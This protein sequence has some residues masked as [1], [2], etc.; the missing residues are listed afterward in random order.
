MTTSHKIAMLSTIWHLLRRFPKPRYGPYG[1]KGGIQVEILT[2]WSTWLLGI[3]V[4]WKESSW[5]GFH[6]NLLFCAIMVFQDRGDGW[7]DEQD[8]SDNAAVQ[9]PD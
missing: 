2:S 9:E 3:G 8:I 6:V 4:F 1:P 7:Y 5:R